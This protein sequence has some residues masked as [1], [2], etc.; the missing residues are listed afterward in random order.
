MNARRF[1]SYAG[2]S[3][4][5]LIAGIASY[6]HMRLVALSTHQGHLIADL[7]P[8]SVDGLVLT[9]TLAIGDGRRSKFTA[10]LAFLIGVGASLV[11]N[12]AAADP[13]LYARC[14]SA[15]PSVGFL[16]A[17]EV[18][19][20][21]ARK[22]EVPAASVAQP[23]TVPAVHTI[24]GDQG[25]HSVEIPPVSAIADS[26]APKPRALRRD[27]NAERVA[28]AAARNPQATSAQLAVKLGLSD[29]T[30][31][32]YLKSDQPAGPEPE[33]SVSAM[34]DTVNGVDVLAD[35]SA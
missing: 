12:V 14:V 5:G 4:V 20:R 8:L 22:A 33:Q 18:L 15:W 17:V 23:V 34:A 29:P 7:L 31:R 30:V 24:N 19:I 32:R 10:W 2:A 35:V 9:A 13:T 26:P 16:L 28:K 1:F 6:D 27:S 21:G 3:L 25:I 11:A